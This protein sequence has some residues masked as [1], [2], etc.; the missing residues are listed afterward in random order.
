MVRRVDETRACMWVPPNPSPPRHAK[1][2]EQAV[3]SRFA[4]LSDEIKD[5][6]GEAKEEH[7]LVQDKLEELARS[8]RRRARP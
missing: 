5:L 6:I 1:G 2:E 7:S 4:E 3:Y 8:S